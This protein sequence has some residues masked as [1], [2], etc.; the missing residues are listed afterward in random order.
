MGLQ[1]AADI[2]KIQFAKIDRIDDLAFAKKLGERTKLDG[3]G[4]GMLARGALKVLL[5]KARPQITTTGEQQ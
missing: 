4:H 1:A 2:R 5:L 3:E